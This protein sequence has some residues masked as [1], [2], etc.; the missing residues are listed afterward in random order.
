MDYKKL[1]N[2]CTVCVCVGV[3]V[4][5]IRIAVVEGAE[6]VEKV[7]NQTGAGTRCKLCQGADVD[8]SGKRDYYIDEVIKS[9][10]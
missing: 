4:G 1:E 2:G 9:E 8:S 3:N 5:Q 7:M 10:K 6:T